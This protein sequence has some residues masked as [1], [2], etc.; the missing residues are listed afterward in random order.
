MSDGHKDEVKHVYDGIEEQDNVM[1]NWWLCILF[2]SIVFAFGY[3]GYYE[4][5]RA[6]PGP[7][8]E[9]EQELLAWKAT[10]PKAGPV[11]D[12]TLVALAAD[13][14]L[15]REGA[16]V[17]TTNCAACHGLQG[18]GVIGPNLT[19]RYWL[20]GAKPSQIQKVI[21]SGVLE[22]GMPSWEPTLGPER[23]KQVTAFVL[24]VKGKN[25]EGKGP[26]GEAIQ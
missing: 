19:D 18:Q 26:Q 17:F 7:D 25:L 2:G 9:Y 15:V 4:T 12:E 13:E 22:K 21:A 3:W 5:F 10:Q 16:E 24:S 23:V 8:G 20:H 11:D 1:P 14:R 6:A